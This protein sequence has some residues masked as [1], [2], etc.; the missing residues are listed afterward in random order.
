MTITRQ[1]LRIDITSFNFRLRHY[2]SE[3]DYDGYYELSENGRLLPLDYHANHDVNYNAF[4]IDLTLRWNFAPGSEMLLNWKN[5]IYTSDNRLSTPY[6][7]NL[8]NTLESPQINSLSLKI[9]YYFDRL[10]K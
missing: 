5:S 3:A 10:F 7:E 8:R 4:N 2:W 9:L 1:E 6:W